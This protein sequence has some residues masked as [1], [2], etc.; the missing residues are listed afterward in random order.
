[1]KSHPREK[2]TTF[3]S[4]QTSLPEDSP[5]QGSHARST[6]PTQRRWSSSSLPELRRTDADLLSTQEPPAGA[7]SLLARG[8]CCGLVSAREESSEEALLFR[9][10]R[11]MNDRR[12][13]AVLAGLPAE[14]LEGL[15]EDLAEAVVAILLSQAAACGERSRTAEPNEDDNASGDL[16]EV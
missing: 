1:M 9:A 15:I 10:N 16:R 2:F 6:R 7:A 4:S 13:E 14:V 12:P 11:A 5:Q 3:T 8:A